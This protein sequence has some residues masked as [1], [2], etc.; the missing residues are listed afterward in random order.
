MEESLKN[1]PWV[2]DLADLVEEC[3][4]SYQRLFTFKETYGDLGIHLQELIYLKYALDASAIVAI[5]NLSGKIIFVND[6]FCEISKYSKEELIGANHR[7]VSSGHHSKA[8]FKKL[9]KTI[10]AGEIWEGEVKNKAKDGT[11]YWVKTTIVPLKDRENRPIMFIAIRTD[12]TK[13]KLA[14]EKLLLSV[15]NDFKKVVSSV[16]N[17]IFKVQKNKND[18][19]I[20]TMIDGKLTKTLNLPIKEMLNSRVCDVFNEE[21]SNKLIR[22]FSALSGEKNKSFTVP[23]Q[24][25]QLM[26]ELTPVS[27]HN[28]ITE[29]IGYVSDV[30]DLMNAKKNIEYMA[31]HDLL[32]NLPNRRKF[33]MDFSKLISMNDS[34]KIAVFFCDIDRFK[35]INDSFG[36]AVGDLFLMEV[37]N[38]LLK[39]FSSV[40]S[41]YRF[42]GDEFII[43]LNNQTDD[44]IV[45]HANR[46]LMLFDQT[47]SLPSNINIY[48]TCS[49]GI[50]IYPDH[51]RTEN[52]LVTFADISM[53]NAKK[54]GR[55]HFRIY[56]STIETKR[57]ENVL[58]EN[59]LRFALLNNE[60]RLVFQPKL[61]LKTNSFDSMETL[62]RW[63]SPKF[64]FVSPERFISIAEETG[65]IVKMDEWVLKNACIQCKKWNEMALTN[66]IKV[67][68]NISPVHFRL[69][70][71]DQKV[72]G[73]LEETGLSPELLEIEIIE[74]SFIDNMNECIK[75]LKSLKDMGVS[76]AIDDFGK[77][78]S[79]LNYLRTFPVQTLKIDRSF[80][81]EMT[82]NDENFAIV[83]AIINLAH[84]LKLKVVAEGIETLDVLEK[85]RLINCDYVQGYYLS[86]PLNTDDFMDNIIERHLLEI[87]K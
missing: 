29:I 65:L 28:Q 56:D 47:I 50:S 61:N 27:Y 12:I 20:F 42:A 63:D 25:R 37:A 5:T 80:I 55:N 44:S 49:V 21:I 60:F 73:I 18:E 76:I 31:Y 11:Y 10:L 30:T 43:L 58:I 41:I 87:T 72:K 75:S 39:E 19:Y 6:K 35:T 16:I 82:Q 70:N 22:E 9:W 45:E 59:E 66:S 79:S 8:F 33:E 84:E 85:L 26:V 83:R 17:L 46:L 32:T 51:S 34:K 64:G 62:I 74:T 48:A 3:N 24:N 68:V 67:A 40:G 86:K 77:G 14:Q 57:K 1:T 2:L 69:A 38:M 54:N 23:F 78:F 36:H 13:G 71:F 53:H 7:I 81:N 4:P 52:E 15:K